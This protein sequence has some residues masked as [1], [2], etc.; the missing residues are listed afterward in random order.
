MDNIEAI[1]QLESL[2]QILIG[3]PIFDKDDNEAID[4]AIEALQSRQQGE[5]EELL[6]NTYYCAN[7][8]RCVVT[9]K[10]E[11]QK[12][13]FCPNCGAPMETKWNKGR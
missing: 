8:D 12:Y 7:C 2:R 1:M 13:N 9:S 3:S 10:K 4:M 5:W 6:P 11:I